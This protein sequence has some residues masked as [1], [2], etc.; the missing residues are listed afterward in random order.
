MYTKNIRLSEVWR[1]RIA[2]AKQC[3]RGDKEEKRSPYRTLHT[4]DKMCAVKILANIVSIP[5]QMKLPAHNF[6]LKLVMG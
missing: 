5:P 2:E 4:N 6:Q 1:K 3:E